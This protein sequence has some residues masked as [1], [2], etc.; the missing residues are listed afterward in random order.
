MIKNKDSKTFII[1]VS[2]TENLNT[3]KKV[4]PEKVKST[5]I[6]LTLVLS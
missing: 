1:L 2:P 5:R 6:N 4:Y 3:L